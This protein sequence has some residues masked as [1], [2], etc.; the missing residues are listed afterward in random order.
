MNYQRGLRLEYAK[1]G[2]ES[3]NVIGGSSGNVVGSGVVGA[4]IAGGGTANAGL[5]NQVLAN[6]GTVGGGWSNM[7]NGASATISGGNGNIASGTYSTI[8]GGYANSAIAG[9]Q[10]TVG[11]GAQ[12]TASGNGATVPGGQ[13]NTASANAA[14]VAGGKGNVAHWDY[15]TVG[16]GATNHASGEYATV[17]G[18][19]DNTASHYAFAAGRR[20]KASHPGAFVWADSTDADFTSTATN[21]FSIRAAGGVRVVGGDIN[22]STGGALVDN[23]GGSIE[24]GP[25]EINLG[26]TPFID[27][28]YGAGVV[29]D[30]NIRLINNANG[31]LELY[32]NSAPSPMAQFNTSGLTVNGTF[33]SASDRN[34]KENFA[35]VQ[36]RE[37]LEKVVALPLS[38]WNYKADKATRHLGPMAQDFYTAFNVGPD[39]KHIATVDADGVALAAIQGLNQKVESENQS[40]RAALEAK[41]AKITALEQRLA[42]LEQL[43]KNQTQ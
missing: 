24:L 26:A 32:Q 30:F 21:Q 2:F 14:T 22:W 4:T 35:P 19:R 18:G 28:H 10:A 33:V 29:Q 37:V 1:S 12:N 38:S 43:I 42:A 39:D 9:Q 31:Q 7:V 3:I 34:A 11:G 16:G 17:P 8:G 15:A 20:A 40:V 27:F 5:I 25:R 41:D 23:Q 13:Q 6:F 36:P